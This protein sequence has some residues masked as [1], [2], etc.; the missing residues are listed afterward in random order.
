MLRMMPLLSTT[1]RLA[2]GVALCGL[3]V[4]C[5][6]D[7][8]SSPDVSGTTQG[9]TATAPTITLNRE[10]APFTAT[11][12]KPGI[13]VKRSA[14]PDLKAAVGAPVAAWFDGAFLGVDYPTADFPHAFDSWTADAGRQAT[15]DADSTTNAT[16]GPDLVA[17]VADRQQARLFVF[18][19]NGV[20]GGATAEVR[21]VLTGEKQ[22]G[23][24]VRYNVSGTV[25]L[26]RD[27]SQWSIFGYDLQRAQEAS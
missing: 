26:T 3:C 6:S 12:A 5:T 20:T 4:G 18:A 16:L 11:L 25:Y 19:H 13:G 2:V 27:G 17:L 24:L 7:D 9:S 8:A 1:S 10:D 22:D 15:A 14:F 21:L 23:S